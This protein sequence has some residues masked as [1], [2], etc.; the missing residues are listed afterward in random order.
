[1]SRLVRRPYIFIHRQYASKLTETSL[2]KLVADELR[3]KMVLLIPKV[4]KK[5]EASG[6][7]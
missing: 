2:K 3:D 7:Y 4:L 1:M 5:T 6:L